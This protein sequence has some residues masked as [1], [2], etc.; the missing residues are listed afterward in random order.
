MYVNCLVGTDLMTLS[1]EAKI[2]IY[3]AGVFLFGV[4][5]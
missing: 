3:K 1:V 4:M 2:R 5:V